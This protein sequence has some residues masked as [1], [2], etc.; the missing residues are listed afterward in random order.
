MNKKLIVII[1]PTAVGKTDLSI[2]IAKYFD[3]PIISSDS[4]QI[5]KE[6]NIGT[7]VPSAQQLKEVEHYFIHTRSITEDYTAGKF[8]KEAIKEISRLFEKHNYIL[9]TGGSGLYIDAICN[10]I[11]ELPEASVG[12]RKQINE[13]YETDGLESLTEQLHL[14]DPE[15]YQKVDLNNPQRVIRALEVCISTGKTYSQLRIGEGKKRDFDIIKVG[16][17]IDRDILYGRINR[18]VD[19]MIEQGLENEALSLY[20]FRY[21]NALQTVGYKELFGFFSGEITKEE[22][23]ELLKRNTRRYAKRQMTWFRKYSDIE[24]FNPIDIE[25]I[26]TYIK[27]R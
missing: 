4:R 13:R 21:L 9:L 1:G 8:E 11:D 26:I 12:V 27:T 18:R 25:K 5:Y 23:I 10:G 7:A 6:M 22:A 19:I 17:T 3:A 16:L 20:E 24:W 14:L 15:Y 2:D